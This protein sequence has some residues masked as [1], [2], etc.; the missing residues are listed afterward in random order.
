M[1]ACFAMVGVAMSIWLDRSF[2]HFSPAIRQPWYESIWV[3]LGVALLTF[4]AAS[5][6]VRLP[7][8]ASA[9]LGLLVT[10]PP[11]LW[12]LVDSYVRRG[13]AFD[14]F[15]VFLVCLAFSGA[16]LGPLA[17]GGGALIRQRL[18]SAN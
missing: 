1:S 8:R 17:V 12:L 11:Y 4:W 16:V 5:L 7:W 10:G 2:A 18:R 15:A 3:P 13:E 6:W 9:L 14:G